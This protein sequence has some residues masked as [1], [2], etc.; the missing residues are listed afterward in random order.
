M[1]RQD[2]GRLTTIELCEICGERPGHINSRWY[3]DEGEEEGWWVC[4]LCEQEAETEIL[5]RNGAFLPLTEKPRRADL[6]SEQ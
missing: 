4:V 1:P 2:W 6:C 5:R 3:K